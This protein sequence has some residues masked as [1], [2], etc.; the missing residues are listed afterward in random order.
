MKEDV[1]QVVDQIKRKKSKKVVDKAGQGEDSSTFVTG[2][3]H[4]EEINNIYQD[5]SGPYNGN[6]GINIAEKEEIKNVKQKLGEFDNQ[7]Q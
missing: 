1:K 5:E 2:K 3:I 7:Q 6:G 4:H